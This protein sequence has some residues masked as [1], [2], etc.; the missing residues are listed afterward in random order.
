MMGTEAR[1][2]ILA[3]CGPR[4][5]DL[6]FG[7]LAGLLQVAHQAT[8]CVLGGPPAVQLGG[9]LPALIGGGHHRV[10]V[11]GSEARERGRRGLYT[12]ALVRS[13]LLVVLIA[14]T[15]ATSKATPRQAELELGLGPGPRPQRLCLWRRL[16]HERSAGRLLYK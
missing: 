5:G 1:E 14:T 2:R 16:R 13:V 4:V 8:L 11:G 9:E 15:A 3:M 7:V 12:V 6:E 10:E